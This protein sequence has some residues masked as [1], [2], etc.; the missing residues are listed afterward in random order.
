[1]SAYGTRRRRRHVGRWLVVGL[2]VAALLTVGYGTLV[3]WVLTHPARQPVESSPARWGMTYRDI[4]FASDKG[5]LR[6][7]GWWIPATHPVGLTVV[8]A[9]GYDTNREESDIPLLAVARAVHLMGAN[10]LL[11]DFRGE[12]R[13]PGSLVSIGYN[14]QWDLLAAVQYAHRQSPASR[15]VIMGYSMG[16]STAILTAARTPLVAGVLADSPFADLKTYLQGSLPVWTHLPAF[17]F[18]AII[19]AIIPRLTG[20]HPSRVD[21]LAVLGALGDRPLLL[22]AGTADTYI[23]DTNAM[24]L[25][26]RARRTDPQAQLWLVAGANHVQGFKVA[27]IAYLQHVY[28]WLHEVDPAVRPLPPSLGF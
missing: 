22:I 18:N 6:L 9:H 28:D 5:G 13:S 4:R 8:F 11:F 17:P 12:G 10:V 19:L 15:I 20:I 25:Y 21:P 16:A 27:P 7:H 1:M 24:E 3:G 14:E 2:L 23:P 26:R